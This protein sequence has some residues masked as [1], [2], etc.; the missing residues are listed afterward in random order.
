MVAVAIFYA[1]QCDKKKCTSVRM[2][3]MED[4]LPFKLFWLTSPRRI[5]RGSVVLT[6]NTDEILLPADRPLVDQRGI[7]VLDCS[8]K[9][10]E[11]YL[12]QS[13]P[14]G[15]KLPPLLAGNPVNYGRWLRLTSAEAVAATLYIVGHKEASLS[16]L[17]LFGWGDSFLELNQ[18]LLDSY[19][20][21]SSKVE[22]EEAFHQL[23]PQEEEN[24]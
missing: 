8:W 5:R 9:Q 2:R 16:L 15:R 22:V 21:C 6:P 3:G 14:V 17:E 18:A 23:Y 12:T 13:F 11:A 7:T 19:T 20:A 4:R 1:D 10:G 24:P